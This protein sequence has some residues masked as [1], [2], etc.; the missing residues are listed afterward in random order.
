M[1][2]VQTCA[3]PIFNN[4]AIDQHR[5]RQV[6]AGRP[7]KPAASV[8][9][10]HLSDPATERIV[11][12]YFITRLTTGCSHREGI[13]SAALDLLGRQPEVTIEDARSTARAA[14]TRAQGEVGEERW[15]STITDTIVTRSAAGP[16]S[17]DQFLDVGDGS[18]LSGYDLFRGGSV[19][20][21]EPVRDPTVG[22]RSRNSSHAADKELRTVFL[23]KFR[24]T[25]IGRASCRERV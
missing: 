10:L 20:G 17:L 6:S 23:E 7:A 3:L 22:A 25:Q 16:V 21:T 9:Y 1:T 2:G 18:R 15:Q 4:V 5:A 11:T 19:T 8:A 12:A 24:L 14:I 13:E